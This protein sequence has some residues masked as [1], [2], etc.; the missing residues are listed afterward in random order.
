MPLLKTLNRALQRLLIPGIPIPGIQH[1]GLLAG[2]FP[3][4]QADDLTAAPLLNHKRLTQLAQQAELFEAAIFANSRPTEQQSGEQASVFL[5][6]GIEFEE[7]R[8]FQ[9]GDSSRDID[10]HA[11]LR[12]GQPYVK[13]RREERCAHLHV[14]IDRR[15]P[16]R[17][18]TRGKLKVSCAAEL[19]LLFVYAARKTNAHISVTTL[20]PAGSQ[21]LSADAQGGLPHLLQ[22]INAPCPPPVK[23]SDAAVYDTAPWGEVLEDIAA[24]DNAGTRVFLLSD[25][26]DLSTVHQNSLAALAYH[27]QLVAIRISDPVENRLPDFG[28]VHFHD[29]SLDQDRELNSGDQKV[30]TTYL[31]NHASLKQRQEDIFQRVGAP[32]FDCSTTDDPFHCFRKVIQHG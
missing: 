14:L 28:I 30:Q 22:A 23:G 13:V 12:R 21:H 6:R 19:A 25:F 17:F 27:H 8:Q 32:L 10:W 15:L 1:A 20:E 3:E 7:L 31:K 16:M 11:S 26:S 29:A 5:G 9:P 18:A 4:N 24:A 2:R